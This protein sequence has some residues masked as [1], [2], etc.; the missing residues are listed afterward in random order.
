MKRGDGE[1]VPLARPR[2]SCKTADLRGLE[3]ADDLAD[4]L[5]CQGLRTTKVPWARGGG[6]KVEI[7][8]K[9]RPLDVAAELRL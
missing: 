6:K 2:V 9:R 7:R 1:Y 8:L 4:V 5:R 3:S